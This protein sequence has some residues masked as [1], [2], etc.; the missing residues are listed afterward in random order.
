M[1]LFL[2]FVFLTLLLNMG[3]D[4]RMCNLSEKQVCVHLETL[5]IKVLGHAI[6]ELLD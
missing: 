2:I 6:A 3:P 4:A 1:N 5:Y